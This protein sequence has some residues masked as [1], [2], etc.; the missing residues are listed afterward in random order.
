[1]ELIDALREGGQPYS[2]RAS[3][4]VDGEAGSTVLMLS[5]EPQRKRPG[6]GG[7]VW[8]LWRGRIMPS[9]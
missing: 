4:G 5:R 3:R 9:W 8:R 1:M 7:E 6:V 2:G